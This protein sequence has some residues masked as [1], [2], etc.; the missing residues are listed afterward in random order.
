MKDYT[1]L[2]YNFIL[3]AEIKGKTVNEL[4]PH[5]SPDS[6]VKLAQAA[7]KAKFNKEFTEEFVTQMLKEEYGYRNGKTLEQQGESLIPQWYQDKWFK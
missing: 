7:L 3:D 5:L 6:N 4:P 2:L 1:K